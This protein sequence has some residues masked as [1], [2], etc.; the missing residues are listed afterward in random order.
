MKVLEI[1][2]A[3]LINNLNI[4]KEKIEKESPH[5]KIIA[6]VKANGMGL[7]LIKYS[8]FLI[9]NEISVLAVATVKE[10]I[11][12]R[13][14][15]I[16]EEILMLSPTIIK[17][18]LQLLIENDITLTVDSLEQID[19]I[20]KILEEYKKD[21]IKAHIKVDTGFGRYGFLYTNK[22]KIVDAFNNSNKLKIDGIFTHFSKPNDEKWTRI[23]F[24]RFMEVISYINEQGYMP[25]NLHAS[26]S[27][28]FLKYP[29]MNL[30]AVRLGS[31]FQGRTI[32]DQDKFKKIGIFKTCISEIKLLP[33]GYN[34][35]YSNTY[36]TKKNT[37]IAII[38][39]GYI[40]GL[41]K[42]KKRDDFSLKNNIISVLMEIKKIFKDNSLKVKIKNNYYKI[43]G[44]IGM[45][46]AII[47]I[48][49]SS[50]INVG[51]EVELNI[52][53]LQAN[54]EIRRE[55]I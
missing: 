7:D 16:N 25:N 46:H 11:T 55:Y 10:A 14:E 51:D 1:N 2:K 29:D 39:V 17:K 35:S 28:A 20:E 5:T 34:I 30:T 42:D 24:D 49:N 23:Q 36:K 37:K 3:N 31:I 4:V 50:N 13:Q 53:P 45:Y 43:I 48:T 47:D 6:V 8:K 12:L 41:N 27:T 26:S 40:D 44:R 32:I 33:K 21:T 9:E 15:G 22:E 18:E 52:T 38:P 54:D 19:L